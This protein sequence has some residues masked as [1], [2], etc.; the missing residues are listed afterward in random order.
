MKVYCAIYII[1]FRHALHFEEME[2]VAKTQ[3]VP[4]MDPYSMETVLQILRIQKPKS[5]LELGAAIGY[6]ALRMADAVQAQI[7]TVERDESRYYNAK[8]NIRL[9]PNG[10]N[11]LIKRRCFQF[12]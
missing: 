3:Q 12:S 11:Y 5:I 4:I 10:N 8:E 1:N 2:N 7:V 6:S 9:H